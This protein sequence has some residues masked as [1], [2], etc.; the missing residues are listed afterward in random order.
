MKLIMLLLLLNI[1]SARASSIA[2]YPSNLYW[3]KIESK[4]FT[5]INPEKYSQEFNIRSQEAGLFYF[6]AAHGSLPAGGAVE[7]KVTPSKIS[8]RKSAIYVSAQTEGFEPSIAIKTSMKSITPLSGALVGVIGKAPTI[9]FSFTLFAI[10]ALGA[11]RL[12]R[13]FRKPQ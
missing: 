11:I 2:V 4:T 6:S 13:R 10:I 9:F 12:I 1:G 3:E 7:I 8:G 5:V